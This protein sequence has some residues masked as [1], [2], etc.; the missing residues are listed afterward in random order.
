VSKAPDHS[1]IPSYSVIRALRAFNGGKFFVTLYHEDDGIWC[2]KTTSQLKY[3][4]HNAE[5][6]RGCVF[7]A[8]GT[9]PHFE[10][11]TVIQLNNPYHIPY[12]KVMECLGPM[13]I[14]FGR[15]FMHAL[16][17]NTQLSHAE[18]QTWLGKL[19]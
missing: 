16:K 18:K 10:K 5:G 13:P 17:M 4:E 6:Y 8:S 14:G 19:R 1:A 15:E 9:C 2:V 11:D 7:V 3:Y 12:D